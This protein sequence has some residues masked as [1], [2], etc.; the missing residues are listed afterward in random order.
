M[1]KILL[2]VAF[3]TFALC[4]PNELLPPSFLAKPVPITPNPNAGFRAAA[5]GARS[6]AKNAFYDAC[7]LGDDLG[8]VTLNA[9]FWQDSAPN[10][11]LDSV[12]F[13]KNRARNFTRDS[14]RFHENS[15]QDIIIDSANLVCSDKISCF[16]I[17][18][19]YLAQIPRDDFKVRF[20]RQKSCDLG[21]DEACGGEIPQMDSAQMARQR[22]YN[23]CYANNPASCY[24]LGDTYLFARGVARDVAFARKLLLK[25]CQNGLKIACDDYMK[26]TR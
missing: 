17:Y 3:V 6:L 7:V 12:R 19:F 26:I 14:A 21:L 9:M 25:G 18:Q 2:L 4:A 1:K 24:A 8:C 22:L 15:P 16:R 10:H 5:F 20:F 13:S 11:S 23:E